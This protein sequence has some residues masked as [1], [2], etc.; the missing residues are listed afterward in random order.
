[1]LAAASC[2][3][4]F[5][6]ESRRFLRVDQMLK[7]KTANA[8]AGVKIAGSNQFVF[9]DSGWRVTA[10]VCVFGAIGKVTAFCEDAAARGGGALAAE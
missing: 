1:M 6:A 8:I 4:V 5:E 2:F 10:I 7:R 9:C 3:S